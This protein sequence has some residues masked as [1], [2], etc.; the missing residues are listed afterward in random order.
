[1]APNVRSMSGAVPVPRSTRRFDRL[2][3]ARPQ[4]DYSPIRVDRGEGHSTVSPGHAGVHEDGSGAAA[5]GCVERRSRP[6][7]L[8]G[9]RRG[10][11]DAARAGRLARRGARRTSCGC[12][13]TRWSSTPAA[14]RTAWRSSSPPTRTAPSPRRPRSC[15]TCAPGSPTPSAASACAPRSPARIRWS[16][17]RTSRSRPAPATSTCTRRCA[18]W[19]GASRPSP[20]TCT[21]PCRTPSS[22]SAR[23]NGMRA[24]IPVL[25]AL[26]ANS[27]FTRGRDTGLASARTPVFQA[28]PRT[29]IPREFAT[30]AEYAEAVDVADPLRRDPG[31]DVHLVG[32]APAAQARH[33]R[34][35]RDGRADPHPRHRRAG[36]A[37]PVPGPDRGA[38][39]HGRAGAHARARGAR[40]EPLPRR[41]RRHQ[42][43]AARS[44]ARP[45]RAR[46][47]PPGDAGGRLLAA[48]AGARLRARAE[49]AGPPRRRS[50]R[51]PPAGDR[52][53]AGG[54]RR[55]GAHPRRPSSRRRGRSCAPRRLNRSVDCESVL[56]R[57]PV[58]WRAGRPSPDS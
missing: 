38:A 4:G 6:R 28:F 39:G 31:A 33:A 5:M 18:S 24:H 16:A 20:C 48:R 17:P 50:G 1:M 36:R 56:F 47:G 15:A 57:H 32:R 11:G 19:P 37:R 29:G 35:A 46:L 14:R 34:G 25:L 52:D 55:P 27:P 44:A 2:S 7:A 41:A 21:S 51:G 8:D 43:P 54:H 9:G 22:P 26:A 42:R 10:G 12:C 3:C 49:A 40:R 13:R 45:L 58:R 53:R 30:Y 23:C